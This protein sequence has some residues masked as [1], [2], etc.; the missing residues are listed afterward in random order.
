MRI[1]FHQ[2]NLMRKQAP[3]DI[4][5][6]AVAALDRILDT[7]EKYGLKAIIDPH[8]IPGTMSATSTSENDPLWH[9][10]AYHDH[11]IRLWQYLAFRCK[12]RGEVIAGYDLLNEPSPPRGA[13]PEGTPADW[14]SLATRLVAAIREID[15][16]H[17]IIAEFPIFA[18]A[19]GAPP[20]VAEMVGYL[21]PIEDD[22]IIYSV[23][24]YAPGEFTHQGVEGRPNGLRYPGFYRGMVWD[25]ALHRKL[26]DPVVDF[27]HKYNVP[28]YLG[29][30]AAARWTGEDGNLWMR[31]VADVAERYGWIWTY[32]SFRIASVWDAEKSGTNPQDETVYETTPR[33]EMLRSYFGRNQRAAPQISDG[34]IMNAA[35]DAG[36]VIAPFMV[37]RLCGQELGPY[38]MVTSRLDAA[39]RV[40]RSLAGVEV[41]F[42]GVP[43][44]LLSVGNKEISG[45]VPASVA[46]Q[47]VAHVVVDAHSRSEDQIVTVEDTAPGLFTAD[48]LGTGQATAL[49]EDLSLNSNRTPARRGSVIILYLTGAGLLNP[50]PEDGEIL[51]GPF[52]LITSPVH[53]SIGGKDADVLYAGPAAQLVGGFVQISTRIPEEVVS[54]TEVPVEIRIGE[55]LSH[56][57]SAEGER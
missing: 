42:D 20:P 43:A 51:R 6:D 46:G 2:L 24:W 3:Y 16:K 41:L 33:I 55:K 40:S 37:F 28:I 35:S 26:L 10:F 45:V 53:V 4:N 36:G 17:S 47:K 25:A 38:E 13:D 23:H 49:N 44:P 57:H 27:Q 39:G 56:A 11:L 19:A 30:F 32:H 15:R 1:N 14:N 50:A 8:T 18:N 9:D 34:C 21:R 52:P 7:C 48:A 5:P 22:N 31:D 29:E 54:G 12:D